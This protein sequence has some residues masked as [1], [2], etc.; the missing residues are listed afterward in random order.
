MSTTRPSRTGAT[1]LLLRRLALAVVSLLGTLV[2]A[3]ILLTL[4]DPTVVL[5]RD[6]T[7]FTAP[8][9]HAGQVTELIPGAVNDHYMG[10]SVRINEHGRRGEESGI[11]KP[12][13]TH[14]LLVVGD[15]IVFG[16][17]V[18]EDEAFHQVLARRLEDE[19]ESGLDYEA[20]NAGLPGAGFSYAYHFLRRS[21]AELNPDHVVL[22]VG[23]NDF[24]QQAPDVL[25]PEPRPAS[26]T[27]DGRFR[28]M[29]R[30]VL[31][32]SRLYATVYPGVKSALYGLGVLDLNKT[33]AFSFVAMQAPSESLEQAWSAS[34]AVLD[35]A[36]R[37]ARDCGAPVTMVIFP[38][39]PQLSEEAYVAYRDRYD[40]Q[41]GPDPTSGAPQERMTDFA[42][43]RDLPVV[44]LLETYRQ[45]DHG[46]LFLRNKSISL[47]FVHPSVLGHEVAAEALFDAMRREE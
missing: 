7:I 41:V 16:F 28:K 24:S 15:S 32:R 22:S 47:D 1:R 44:D 29:S 39:E 23:L 6:G 26:P 21:C 42:E 11:P 30:A 2:V 17:G 37:S 18:E 9:T 31:G 36:V 3:E 12:D 25:S 46:E 8:S 14:R 34:L 43:A 35:A 10:S 33:T 13:G 40:L 5:I 38:L 20:V 27:Y 19:D 45:H 4:L